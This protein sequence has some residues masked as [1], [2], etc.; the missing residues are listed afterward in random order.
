MTNPKEAILKRL[1][2]EPLGE[3]A[4]FNDLSREIPEGEYEEVYSYLI[5]ILCDIE[6][7][8][9]EAKKH[10]ENIC[11]HKKSME[12]ALGRAVGFRVGM[13]DYFLN[14]KHKLQNP[15]VMELE[16][17][18]NRLRL[19]DIDELTGLYNRRFFDKSVSTELQR[20]KRYNM[21]FSIMFLD[22]DDFKKIN[23][24]YGHRQGDQVLRNFAEIISQLIRAE[25]VAARYGGEEFIILIPQ[26]DSY[27]AQVLYNRIKEALDTFPFEHGI[28]V[29]VS[30]GIAEYPKHGTEMSSLVENAD[31]ALYFSKGSG[32]NKVTILEDKRGT[33][34]YY[35]RRDLT[36]TLDGDSTG[37]GEILDLSLNGVS[38]ESAKNMQVGDLITLWVEIPGEN[39]SFEIRTQIVWVRENETE[40]HLNRAGARLKNTEENQVKEM[41]DTIAG[42]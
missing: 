35:P 12:E 41:I 8:K 38:F 39:R 9:S 37:S 40:S 10:F 11:A 1:F 3:E 31:R 16:E 20:S 17:Y 30:A 23:D 6:I 13:L 27:N 18:E 7:D 29:T 21:T 4:I 24:N 33:R 22:L 36:V 15:K 5:D 32:K 28:Q 2:N 42:T 19:A 34:R 25:D 26:T 14:E